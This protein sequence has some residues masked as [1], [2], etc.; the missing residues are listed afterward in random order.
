MHAC[1]PCSRNDPSHMHVACTCHQV[2]WTH[3][4]RLKGGVALTRRPRGFRIRCEG[5]AQCCSTP[6]R[7]MG[8]THGQRLDHNRPGISRSVT[9]PLLVLFFEPVL[10]VTGINY[11]TRPCEWTN[12]PD[13]ESE[14]P[15]DA[16]DC[17]RLISMP[18]PPLLCSHENVPSSTWSVSVLMHG[19]L[20]WLHACACMR[21]VERSQ[22]SKCVRH[23][24]CIAAIPCSFVGIY[25][26]TLRL[27]AVS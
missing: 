8:R 3:S 17:I 13:L 1:P 23:A 14:F 4:T 7:G 10:C 5:R 27:L 16:S 6:V 9:V 20:C 15:I 2:L 26:P 11:T 22:T 12:L 24:P 25:R 21:I 19:C 18:R